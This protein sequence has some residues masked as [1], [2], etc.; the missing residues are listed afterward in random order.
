MLL[1]EVS[2][3]TLPFDR[4]I[5]IKLYAEAGVREAWLVNLIDETV[6]QYSSPE[7]GRYGTVLTSKRG[8]RIDSAFVE[9]L[10]VTAE[11]ILGN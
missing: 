8:D 3:S 9:S 11:E 6:E 1:I 5:K 4:D 10:S 7:N 2:D